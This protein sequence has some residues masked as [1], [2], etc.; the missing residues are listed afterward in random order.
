ML[1]YDLLRPFSYL[2]V[3][4]G[5]KWRLD[6]AIPAALAA[7]STAIVGALA[8][9]YPVAVMGDA[10]LIAKLLSFVQSLPGF[11]IAALAAIAT[12]NR[13]DID[14]TMPAPPP[15]IQ[16]R[17]RGKSIAI[18]LTRRR[19]LC[20]LLAFLTAESLCLIVAA[21][22]AIA[23]APAMYELVRPEF[24]FWIKLGFLGTYLLFFWQLLVVTFIGLFYLGDRIHQPD[25]N[26]P[27]SQM[28]ARD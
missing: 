12:F 19:Y 28:P 14:R 7:A 6:W 4:Y 16:I 21:I 8:Y 9:C 18:D 3:D 15:K 20:V 17:V 13:L 23:V 25:D 22:F 11:Y 24:R 10:G 26:V 2:T 5:G 1:F 27:L